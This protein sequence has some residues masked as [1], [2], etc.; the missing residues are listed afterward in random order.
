MLYA[1][2]GNGVGPNAEI[3]KALAD[4]REKATADQV[5]FWLLLEAKDEPTKIDNLIAK[6]ANDNEVWFET[7]TATDAAIEGAQTAEQN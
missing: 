5:D 7:I 3:T 2:A 6:W 1:I 4:L